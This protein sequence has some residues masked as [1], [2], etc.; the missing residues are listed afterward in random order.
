MS[1][2]CLR[3]IASAAIVL[4]GAVGDALATAAPAPEP[5]T[6]PAAEEPATPRILILLAEGFQTTEFSVPYHALYA[7]GYEVDVAGVQKG[8]VRANP[9]RPSPNDAHAD[10]ALGEVDAGRYLGLVLPG[11]YSPGRLEKHAESLAICRK[12]MA[13]GKVVAGICHGP[14]LLMRAKLLKRRV[15]TCLY[16][17]ADELADAW[18]AGEYGK[19]LDEPMVVDGN[20]VTSRCPTDINDFVGAI[21]RRLEAAGG[22]PAPRRR[23]RALLVLP[24]ADRHVR[25][26]FSEAPPAAGLD[27]TVLDTGNLAEFAKGPTYEPKAFDVLAVGGGEGAAK[28][29]DAPAFAGLVKDVRAAG[30]PVIAF[31]EAG[32]LL[33]AMEL[34]DGVVEVE[35]GVPG[36]MRA[37][38]LHAR[39]SA[40][41]R[42]AAPQDKPKQAVT[43]Q[44]HKGFDDK[45]LSAVEV[46]LRIKGYAP[47]I[48]AAEP[49]WVLGAEGL[50]VR[51]VSPIDSASMLPSQS[52]AL[53]SGRPVVLP[54]AIAASKELAA[55]VAEAAKPPPKAETYT[56][57][58]ALRR[59]FDGRVAAAMRAYLAVQ[60]RTVA[61]VAH[62]LGRRRG[63]NGVTFEATHTYDAPPPLADSA[64][65]VLPGGV[66]PEKAAARQATQPE[67]IEQQDAADRKRMAWVLG[68]HGSGATLVAAGLD[69]LRLGRGRREFRGKRFACTPQAAWS[70]GRGGGRYSDLAAVATAERVIT[71]RGAGALAAALKLLGEGE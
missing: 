65:V 40:E 42:P 66:W 5:P 37:M 9:G 6:R 33:R 17:V 58:I 12:F 64:V 52:R 26:L 57:A 10:L 41:A 38:L 63:L 4:A 19:Y 23:A 29:K 30:K 24:G 69:S 48:A 18:A 31:N 56:A 16:Q 43:I 28:L 47:L 71:A 3:L 45:A 39:K 14:R 35:A 32:G 15:A 53:A 27:V 8:V 44:L 7:A 36:M 61:I 1:A 13:G 2:I 11:G 62:K 54:P 25:R 59:G 46:Y 34:A 22:R 55:I 67:W 60:G 51:A 49:G 21:L 20:L 70:F 68:R 50:P